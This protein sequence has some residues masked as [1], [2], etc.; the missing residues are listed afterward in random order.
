MLTITVCIWWIYDS[1]VRPKFTFS[2]ISRFSNRIWCERTKFPFGRFFPFGRALPNVL[3]RHRAYCFFYL[4]A[5]CF[6]PSLEKFSPVSIIPI[7]IFTSRCGRRIHTANTQSSQSHHTQ[8]ASSFAV[9]L[10]IF[11]YR[12]YFFS[13]HY[14]LIWSMEIIVLVR[15]IVLG[16]SVCYEYWKP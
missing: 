10:V 4:D 12:F 13:I 8:T 11:L 7:I 15:R 3:K 16:A 6:F 9:W 5:V 14:G 1:I 2:S